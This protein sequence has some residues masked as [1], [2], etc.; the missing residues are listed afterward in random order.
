[1]SMVMTTPIMLIPNILNQ[2]IF[3]I[4]SQLS[5]VKG[6]KKKQAHLINIVLRYML[7]FS[8][9]FAILLLIFFEPAILFFKIKLEYLSAMEYLPI[10][11]LASIIFG[12]GNIYLSSLYAIGRPKINRNI[13]VL[14]AI[15]FLV[16]SI[17]LTYFFSAY[18]LSCSYLFSVSVLFIL[19][20]LFAKKYL[21]IQ[22]QWSEIGKIIFSSLIL[23]FLVYSF[24]LLF[25]RF[26]IQ[27]ILA[28]FSILAY[29]L[30]FIPLK[31]YNNED[32]QILQFFAQRSPKK[33]R[34]IIT[35][36]S[37]F[38]SRFIIE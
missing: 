1:M 31:F 3:P 9:P 36:I 11:S 19:S 8:L 16:T 27:G 37:D 13:T 22:F 7:L 12:C 2:A 33:L 38:L 32:L 17:I 20:F 26:V 25:P 14:T 10:L 6:S 24:N 18:G 28:L 5:A 23:L 4:M 34:N 29:F 30:I 35:K 21:S 15:V